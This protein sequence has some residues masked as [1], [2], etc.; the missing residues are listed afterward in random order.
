ML[1]R[2]SRPALR[3][4]EPGFVGSLLLERSFRVTPQV[5]D[6]GSCLLEFLHRLKNLF[7]LL[8]PDEIY[9]EKVVPSLLP[10]RARFYL[11]EVQVAVR[12][13]LEGILQRPGLIGKGE[14]EARAVT[15]PFPSGQ[16]ISG[17]DQE[18]GG[19]V[20]AILNAFRLEW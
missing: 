9:E 13:R 5:P 3:P 1:H 19:V 7:I 11:A 4:G 12:E 6:E 10:T 15:Y 16:R 18:A 17:H 8:M 2:G 20:L 14:H